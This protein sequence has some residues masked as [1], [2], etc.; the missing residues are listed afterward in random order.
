MATTNHLLALCT[1]AT[2]LGLS[3]AASAQEI[4]PNDLLRQANGLTEG[5]LA[6]LK[7]MVAVDSPTYFM[8]GIAKMTELIERLARQWQARHPSSGSYGHRS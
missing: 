5:T 8:P 6:S 1:F 2:L 4:N 3:G 7:E